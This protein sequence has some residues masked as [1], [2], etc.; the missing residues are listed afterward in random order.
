[1]YAD[2]LAS[3]GW[4][5]GDFFEWYDV[6]RVMGR[7]SSDRGTVRQ[8]FDDEGLTLGS[9]LLG[10]PRE[11]TETLGALPAPRAD[12]PASAAAPAALAPAAAAPAPAPAPAP[13]AA[14]AAVAVA[15]PAVGAGGVALA[16]GSASAASADELLLVAT[17]PAASGS[18]APGLEVD[19]AHADLVARTTARLVLSAPR[20][21]LQA[22][23]AV[24]SE[25][26]SSLARVVPA[27]DLFGAAVNK[28]LPTS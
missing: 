17:S 8:Y 11:L 6:L 4:P 9:P 27:R 13:A 3:R 18:P 10:S 2:W 23:A 1:L 20:Y 24:I 5:L 12:V 26:V 7:D 22:D 19:D 16:G 28:L 21:G 15:V 25:A 14:A